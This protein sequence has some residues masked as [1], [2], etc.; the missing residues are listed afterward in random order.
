MEYGMS[1]GTVMT[2]IQ[3]YWI[4]LN[5]KSQWWHQ[6]VMQRT[7]FTLREELAWELLSIRREL[8]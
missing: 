6:G 1:S 8:Q 4:Q 5:I 2:V 7:S 3:L